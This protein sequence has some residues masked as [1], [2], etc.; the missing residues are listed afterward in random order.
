MKYGYARVSTLNQDLENQI[1]TLEK[2]NC[3]FIYSEKY[4]GTKTDRPE[5]QKLLANLKEGDTLIVTKLDRF[6]RSTVDGIHTIKN[7]F[8]KGVKVHILNMGLVENTPT[9]R[10]IFN[11]MSAFAEFERDMIV[12]RTQEGKALAKL[13]VDFREGRPKKY[14]KKQI[15]HA[16]SLLNHHS[17]KEVEEKTG[18]SKSTLTRA[19]RQLKKE[20]D[21]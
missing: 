3:D 7:L 15:E 20:Q 8:E 10:L 11:I 16:L 2:E 4:T 9:G 21:T 12:E 6:A 17:Y 1:A 14:Q 13:R 18:I 19:K 5:F